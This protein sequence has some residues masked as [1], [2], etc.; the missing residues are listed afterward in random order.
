MKHELERERQV[1]DGVA[2][3]ARRDCG[4]R[5]PLLALIAEDHGGRARVKR[6]PHVLVFRSWPSCRHRAELVQYASVTEDAG[7]PGKRSL[8][9]TMSSSGP[10]LVLHRGS[11]SAPVNNRG[12]EPGTLASC[13]M[14]RPWRLRPR[15]TPSRRSRAKLARR[16]VPMGCHDWWESGNSG[17]WPC[18]QEVAAIRWPGSADVAHAP[19]PARATGA[20]PSTIGVERLDKLCAPRTRRISSAATSACQSY[21]PHVD[22]GMMRLVVPQ[23]S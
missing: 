17:E 18:A 6:D 19:E 21:A 20:L 9:A 1:R 22:N 3:R 12:R 8:K 4:R 10:D 15:T 2:R 13:S 7:A 5:D 16:A 23:S 11:P 14:D